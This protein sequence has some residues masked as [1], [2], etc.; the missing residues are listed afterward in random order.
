MRSSTALKHI[1]A[2]FEKGTNAL[3]PRVGP[4][5]QRD[6]AEMNIT[7]KACKYDPS[8]LVQTLALGAMDSRGRAQQRERAHELDDM[9]ELPSF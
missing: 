6:L 2:L 8:K 4:N 7:L 1:N 9:E 5:I 3:K